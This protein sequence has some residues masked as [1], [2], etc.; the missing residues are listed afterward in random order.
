MQTYTVQNAVDLASRNVKGLITLQNGNLAVLV[1]ITDL[2]SSRMW[3]YRPWWQ[4]LTTIA[5]GTLPLVDGIQD[6]S[7]PVNIYRLTKCSL[8][9]TDVTPNQAYELGIAQDLS[10]DLTK[11]VH[12]SIRTASYQA[13]VGKIRLEAAVQISG[14]TAVQINGEYQTN[15]T[16]ITALNQ[17]LWFQD[18]VLF[19]AFVE[20]L[21]YYAYQL[22][23]D[24]RAGGVQTIENGQPVYA[25]QMAQWFA[26]MN[27]AAKA[28]DFPGIETAFPAETLGVGRDIGGGF[29]IFPW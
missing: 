24:L 23:D 12:T 4:T 2:V 17:Q 29:S 18:H 13:G 25:G 9:R 26:A 28:E 10:V 7:A 11:R 15:P 16:K 3:I 21:K 19:G 1:S 27:D 20:G 14:T 22:A 5:P 8:V 6:Y